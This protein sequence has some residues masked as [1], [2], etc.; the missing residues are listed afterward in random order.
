MAI[1]TCI[2]MG[3]LGL[4]FSASIRAAT[5]NTC[6][7]LTISLM[8]CFTMF[9]GCMLGRGLGQQLESQQAI[10]IGVISFA[11]VALLFLVTQELLSEAREVAGENAFINGMFFVGVLAG[12]VLDKALQ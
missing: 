3:F 8:P 10:F 1:A 9:G 2:E 6:L 4:S 11:L 5:T 7:W 12:M